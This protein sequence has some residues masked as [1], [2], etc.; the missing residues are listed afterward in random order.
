M[1]RFIKT[2]GVCW[3]FEEGFTVSDSIASL[4]LA[5]FCE[6]FG[7][8]S[9]DLGIGRFHAKQTPLGNRPL[10]GIC[11]FD[12]SNG[13]LRLTQRLAEKFASVL[14]SAAVAAEADGLVAE[15]AQLRSMLRAVEKLKEAPGGDSRQS[16]FEVR[17]PQAPLGGT[18]WKQ[19]IGPNQKAL[20]IAT[21][22][23]QEV[24]VL[25]YIVTGEGVKYHLA[26]ADPKI[27]WMVLSDAI[28]PIHGVTEMLWFNPMTGEEMPVE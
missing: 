1:T 15:P 2:T 8:Q 24:T 4:I 11:I 14:E 5:A 28:E 17:T 6:Q 3:Y 19:V 21:D 23:S 7:I 13:S 9:R 18:E 26:H 10:N 12:D 25:R 16:I 22:G 20:L 27:R